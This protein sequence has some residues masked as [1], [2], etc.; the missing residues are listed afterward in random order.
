MKKIFQ[1]ILCMLLTVSAFVGCAV[2]CG[3]ESSKA[4]IVGTIEPAVEKST[5][6]GVH[7]FTM[8]ETSEYLVKDGKTDYVLVTTSELSAI[9][10]T[11]KEEFIDLFREATGIR[12]ETKAAEG[13]THDPNG[14]YICL[15]DNEL[16][17]SSG[18]ELDKKELTHEGVRIVTKDKTVYV[19]G[20][21]AY[22]TLYAVYDFM[23][24]TFNFEQ[25]YVDC[26]EIDT[27]VKEKKLYDYNV[28]DIP[29]LSN[30]ATNFGW[31]TQQTKNRMRM[32]LYSGNYLLP[33][34]EKMT[35]SNGDEWSVENEWVAD[36]SSFGATG[37]NSNEYLPRGT[38]GEHP[39]WF[40]DSGDVLCYTSHGDEAELELMIQECA[41]KIVASLI[42]YPVDV[43]PNMNAAS[44]TVE[45]N[46]DTCACDA[47]IACEEQYGAKSAA[48]ILFM[49]RLNAYV[50]DW[51][52][53]HKDTKYYREN[54]EL[55]FFAYNSFS[56]APAEWD[57]SIGAYVPNA[58]ELKL[59]E[60]VYVWVAL[61]N[62]LEEEINIYHSK[63]DRGRMQ[64]EKWAALSDGLWLWTY[65]T[66]FTEYL[67]FHDMFSLFNSEGYRFFADNKVKLYYQ[68]SQS[69]QDGTSTAFHTL[70]VYLQYK[71]AW[72]TSLNTDELVD[73]FMNAMFKE[74]APV[75]KELLN[76]MRMHNRQIKEATEYVNS[77]AYAQ[78]YP[79]NTL[80]KWMDMCDQA[81]AM[82]E[83][84]RTQDPALYQSLKDHIE[85][86]WVFPAY[87][88]LQL[89]SSNLL[90]GELAALKERFKEVGLRLGITQTKE[91]EVE[92]AFLNF[93]NSL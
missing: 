68:N 24:L 37:H 9:E 62:M 90:S 21:G 85:T 89:R 18:I 32:P 31:F 73:R 16:F 19:T 2:G 56:L 55:V 93:L 58:P 36:K 72:N 69:Y 51:M 22:G 80:K 77:V 42:A 46:N 43:Y 88:T 65:S 5:F 71:L 86:E 78:N 91:V 34:H 4:T 59:D 26:M 45:D 40:G 30:R 33:I 81:L 87:A 23:A 67:Y 79:Y 11:A 29:D 64:I 83:G 41:K 61:M 47:C 44:L 3:K 54:F 60:G 12:L 82:V 92:N 6:V 28:T 57:D 15:G 49:N 53:A 38:Y 17:A 8:T 52:E 13:M 10:Q 74:A 48:I 39:K 76:S 25:Y 7:D 20:G 14:R 84:Y 70:S 1:R 50:R 35:A 75:M 27:G 66:N 63:N